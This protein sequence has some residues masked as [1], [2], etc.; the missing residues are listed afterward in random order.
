MTKFQPASWPTVIPRVFTE[1]VA[2]VIG[3]LKSVFG[4]HGQMRA[5][6]PAEM[7]IGDSL[8]MVSDGGG[9]REARPAFLYVYVE[10]TDES[11][12]LAVDAG[13]VTI[14]EPA[15]MPYGDRRATVQDPWGNIWQI[16]THCGAFASS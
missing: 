7:R 1:D 4:A 13:A 9:V 3:F 10:N 2:G 11:H 5:G 6:A 14:E 16:A 12:Q 8:I 15:D